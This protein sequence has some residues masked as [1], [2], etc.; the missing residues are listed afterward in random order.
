MVPLP[1]VTAFQQVHY[2]PTGMEP[3]NTWQAPIEEQQV[4]ENGGLGALICGEG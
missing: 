2:K 3:L 4:V 1:L